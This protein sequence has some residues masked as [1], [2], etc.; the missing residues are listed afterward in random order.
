M[1]VF[2]VIDFEH[3][4]YYNYFLYCFDLSLFVH[5]RETLG[6]ISSIWGKSLMKY[7]KLNRRKRPFLYLIKDSAETLQR[8]SKILTN[9]L[10]VFLEF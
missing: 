10:E 8:L 3:L 9:S 5:L 7:S 4:F 1:G 6:F 2:Q